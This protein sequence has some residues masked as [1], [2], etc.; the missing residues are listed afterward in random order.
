MNLITFCLWLLATGQ[1]P[2]HADTVKKPTVELEMTMVS[3]MSI[4]MIR[5]TA[6][7]ITDISRVLGDGYVE[8]FTYINK[9]HLKPGKVMAFYHSSRPPMIMD[10]AVQVDSPARVTTGRIKINK[11][12]AGNAVVAHYQGPYEQIGMAYAA[13]TK[14]LQQQGKIASDAP[15]EVYLND[16]MSVKDPS[17]LRTDVYQFVK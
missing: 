15:F 7:A 5:D 8:I 6:A 2:S 11:V 14:W 12:L 10:V 9:N 17:E 4:L 1:A 13:I 16:P 3:P